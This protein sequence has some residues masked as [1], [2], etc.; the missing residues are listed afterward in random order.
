MLKLTF[1]LFHLKQFFS[2][3]LS[4]CFIK[5]YFFYLTFL[6]WT[7]LS[8]LFFHCSDSTKTKL[9]SGSFPAS[10]FPQ[11]MD[12]LNVKRPPKVGDYKGKVL[13][14]FFWTGSNLKSLEILNSFKTFETENKEKVRVIAIHSPKFTGEANLN[15]VKNTILKNRIELTVLHDP[16]FTIWRTYGINNWN[17]LL[18]IGEDTKVIGRF[19]IDK[20]LLRIDPIFEKLLNFDVV[21]NISKVDE[22]SPLLEKNKYPESILSFPENVILDE[23]GKFLYVSDS[24]HNRILVINRDTGFIH[25]VIG[26]GTIGFENGNYNQ[27]SFNYP[28]GLALDSKLLYIVDNKNHSLRK[29]DLEKKIVTLYSGTGKKGDEVVQ[30]GFA[31][32]TSFSFPYGITRDGSTLYLSN[33]GF[34]QFI[35]IDTNSG[36]IE[37]LFSETKDINYNPEFFSK[38]GMTIYRD[39]IFTTDSSSGSLKSVVSDFPSKVKILIGTKARDVGDVD[40]EALKARLQFPKGIFAKDN[41]VYIADTLNHKIKVFDLKKKIVSTLAGS[42]KQGSLNSNLK[43]STFH[44]PSSVY[45]YG[46]ELFVADTNNHC[47]RIINLNTNKVS[48]FY[49]RMEPDLVM[50]NKKKIAPLK[51][52]FPHKSIFITPDILALKL[53]IAISKKYVWDPNGGFY[54]KI[55][56]SNPDVLDFKNNHTMV[57]ENFTG[58]TEF[59]PNQKKEGSTE[60]T[61]NSIIYF[62]S[63]TNLSLC[64]YKKFKTTSIVKIIP[65]GRDKPLMELKIPVLQREE[66]N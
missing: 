44:E 49:I 22:E 32:V 39:T 20:N 58:Q 19:S 5:H 60:I 30:T 62:C 40:G 16:N 35:K 15:Y 11:G 13:V 38:V 25:D 27:S 41:L 65:G 51:D 55:Q 59:F 53:K 43:E 21:P 45:L 9:G 4:I 50:E 36:K 8:F 7:T 31:P 57:F 28:T 17:S 3:I 23:Y 18:V 34:N 2:Q 42:G 64:Y 24:N 63:K 1:A 12:W 37:S 14:L 10:E 61:I 66:E 52:S 56:S 33:T 47:I 54:F 46:S 48:T 29:V 6:C 26:N